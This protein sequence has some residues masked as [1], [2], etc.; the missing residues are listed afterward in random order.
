[1]EKLELKYLAPYLPYKLQ[2]ISVEDNQGIE[3]LLSLSKDEITTD[4]DAIVYSA[5]KPILRPLSD[6]TKEIE[7]NGEKFV[8]EEKLEE[9]DGEYSIYY[10]DGDIIFNDKCV[11]N[12]YE[13]TRCNRLILKLCEWHFDVFG[14]IGD[15]LAIDINT[16]TINK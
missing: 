5:W 15:G 11:L 16:L 3:T 7:V 2:G 4:I 14:L 12:L 10:D 8:P 6:L 9:V 13:V 1:M